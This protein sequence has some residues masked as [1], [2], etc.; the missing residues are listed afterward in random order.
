MELTTDDFLIAA[1]KGNIRKPTIE[2][3]KLEFRNCTFEEWATRQR[4]R[5]TFTEDL[6]KRLFKDK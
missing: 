1:L 4:I 3:G 5:A 2:N 6:R